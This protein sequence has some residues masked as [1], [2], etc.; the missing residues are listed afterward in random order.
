MTTTVKY[1]GEGNDIT[2][3]TETDGEAFLR[4][5]WS[6]VTKLVFNDIPGNVTYI[7]VIN[8]RGAVTSGMI[9]VKQEDFMEAVARY[10]LAKT[11]MEGNVARLHELSELAGTPGINLM[12][13]DEERVDIWEEIAQ[14]VIDLAGV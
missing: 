4:N 9:I 11:N 10:I 7:E 12:D 6:R 14:A 8:S 13:I 2:V 3:I 5:G 1:S